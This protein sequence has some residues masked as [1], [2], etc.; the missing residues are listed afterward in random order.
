MKNL[1]Q[2][3]SEFEATSLLAKEQLEI[4][5]ASRDE[6]TRDLRDELHALREQVSNSNDIHREAKEE[7]EER[8]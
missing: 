2:E 4:I 3:K 5:R 1:L 7:L 8:V 6:E